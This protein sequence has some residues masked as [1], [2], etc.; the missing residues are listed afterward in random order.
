MAQEKIPHLHA[1]FERAFFSAEER[2][3]TVFAITFDLGCLVRS[4]LP[5]AQR[6]LLVHKCNELKSWGLPA[7]G[8]EGNETNEDALFRELFQETGYTLPYRNEGEGGEKFSALTIE[9]FDIKK[10][11]NHEKVLFL[12]ALDPQSQQA[13]ILETSEIDGV[14]WFTLE[15]IK[16]FSHVPYNQ[17]AVLPNANYIKETH[18][19]Y[20]EAAL[21]D[22]ARLEAF[23][24][25]IR[26]Y[27][28]TART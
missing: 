15:E 27:A 6:F 23:A 18:R 25:R 28:T 22:T 14:G 17:C 1:G 2:S 19:R 11:T 20:I 26:Q 3:A 21:A 5:E 12:V 10:I 24:E 9:P 4:T 13:E 7:G 8:V 16:K